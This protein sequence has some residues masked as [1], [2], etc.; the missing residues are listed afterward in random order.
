MVPTRSLWPGDAGRPEGGPRAVR[1]AESVSATSSWSSLGERPRP[2][3]APLAAHRAMTSV[4]PE[5]P[6]FR[7]APSEGAEAQWAL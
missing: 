5:A 7:A 1:G 4:L 6:S 3:S 2:R